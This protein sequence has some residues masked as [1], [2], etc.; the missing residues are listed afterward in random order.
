MPVNAMFTGDFVTQLVV[1]LD[2]DTV[3]G[4]AR[5]VAAQVVGRR[6]M[7]RALSVIAWDRCRLVCHWRPGPSLF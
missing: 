6:V 2:T 5:R 3:D 7:R 1:L 4:A